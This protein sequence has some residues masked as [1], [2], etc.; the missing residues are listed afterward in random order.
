[1][2]M[3]GPVPESMLRPEPPDITGI[4][5]EDDTPVDNMGSEKHQRLL[6]ES[7][8]SS[9]T[10]PPPGEDGKP[11]PFLAAANVGVFPSVG[12]QPL[13]PDMFLSVDVSVHPCFWDKRHRTYFFWEF[14][15]PPEVVIE[16]VSNREGDELTRKKARYARMRIAYY[17]VYDP[18][19]Y[20][21]EHTL[22]VFKLDGSVVRPCE[23]WFE[24]IGLG[25]VEWE[26]VFEGIETRW[27][28]WC[29]K[30]GV[31]VPTGA[32]RAAKA[33]A[34]AA[35]AQARAERLA[36]KL[37]ALGIDPNGEGS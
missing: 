26:G 14:G 12:E 7:L 1:M 25:L 23:P 20:L 11:R 2:A 13:V 31:L 5:T 27:L 16:I 6:T 19:H 10:G 36:E 21:G 8:Y 17:V 18:G 22:H 37:R 29:T 32:E 15:K 28:R 34:E 9:W 33:M 3:V 30:G 4:V 24:D 35:K